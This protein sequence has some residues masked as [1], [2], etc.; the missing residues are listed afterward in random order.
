MLMQLMPNNRFINYI[1]AYIYSFLEKLLIVLGKNFFSK[2]LL[3]PRGVGVRLSNTAVHS[4]VFGVGSYFYFI[5]GYVFD[6]YKRIIVHDNTFFFNNTFLTYNIVGLL[7]AINI[8]IGVFSTNS[9]WHLTN[10]V[11]RPPIYILTTLLTGVFAFWWRYLGTLEDTSHILRSIAELSAFTCVSWS[12]YALWGL[13]SDYLVYPNIYGAIF[14]LIFHIFF[15]LFAIS[16]EMENEPNTPLYGVLYVLS[17]TGAAFSTNGLYGLITT[18]YTGYWISLLLTIL[19]FVLTVVFHP[20]VYRDSVT[21]NRNVTISVMI[22]VMSYF[23]LLFSF[24]T[25]TGLLYQLILNALTGL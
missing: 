23:I 13:W 1:V 6:R 5:F 18:N 10:S 25:S 9:F 12:T 15:S 11:E 20:N 16:N 22:Y 7:Y 4:I 24:V 21:N 8:N 2:K 14:G 19:G 17:F 3:I